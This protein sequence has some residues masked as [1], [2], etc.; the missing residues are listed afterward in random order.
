MNSH[1]DKCLSFADPRNQAVSSLVASHRAPGTRYFRGA[2]RPSPPDQKTQPGGSQPCAPSEALAIVATPPG[3]GLDTIGCLGPQAI[4]IGQQVAVG[5]PL[6]G[7]Y[8]SANT[9][10]SS[11]CSPPS[12]AALPLLPGGPVRTQGVSVN[13]FRS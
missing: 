8:L 5:C 10:V 4:V 9:C 6:V 12:S 11:Y 7:A 1:S 13:T 2:C 3:E